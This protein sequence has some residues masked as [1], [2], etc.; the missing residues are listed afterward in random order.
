MAEEL[1]FHLRGTLQIKK[2]SDLRI[3]PVIQRRATE[4]RLRKLA[5]EWDV[6]KIGTIEVAQI[7]DSE[8]KGWLHPTDGGTRV[9]AQKDY[10]DPDHLFLCVVRPMTFIEAANEFLYQNGLS[11][12]PSAFSKYA[13]GVQAGVA[14]ALAVKRALDNLDISASPGKSVYGNGEAGTF[15]AFAQADKIVKKAFQVTGD[16][17]GATAHFQWCLA[18]GR[19]AYPQHGDPG[20]AM[21]HDANLI[22]AISAL[23]ILNPKLTEG[24]DDYANFLHAITTWL[25]EG[26]KLTKLF[27][28]GQLMKPEHWLVCVHAV[29]KNSGG[30]SSRG[31]QMARQIGLNYGRQFG[32]LNKPAAA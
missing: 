5:R 3:I 6:R 25:G 1:P 30:G 26:E 21:G 29:T 15:A 17:D 11:Q 28:T 31:T 32:R 14:E 12:N 18:T 10:G 20:T 22:Q 19:E 23:G 27:E 13:V 9:T 7:T 8:Y 2:A 16:W 24:G 4:D